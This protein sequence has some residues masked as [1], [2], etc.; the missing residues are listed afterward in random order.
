MGHV[1]AGVGL[2]SVV[3]PARGQEHSMQDWRDG[4]LRYLVHFDDGGSGMRMRDRPL[5]V[6]CVWDDGGVRSASA[7]RQAR[8]C[9]Q[10]ARIDPPS[11][12]IIAPVM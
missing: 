4:Q 3:R 2:A 9:S 1:R 7:T 8:D 11:T 5:Q 10:I 12:G 6:G